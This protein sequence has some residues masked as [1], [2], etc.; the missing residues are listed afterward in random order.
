M[1]AQLWGDIKC[2][3]LQGKKNSGLQRQ[4]FTANLS[5]YPFVML[6]FLAALQ[7]IDRGLYE[8]A[9]ID[10]AGRWQMFRYI[11]LPGLKPAFVIA[12]IRGLFLEQRV[13]Q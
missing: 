7:S 11:T 4:C 12:I 9:Q 6:V 2:A 1:P 8:S 13:A 3:F 10:G 5:F